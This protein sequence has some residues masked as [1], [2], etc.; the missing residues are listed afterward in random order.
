MQFD[1]MPKCTTR[2]EKYQNEPHTSAAWMCL[3]IDMTLIGSSV[4]SAFFAGHKVTTTIGKGIGG[5]L[6]A[7][8]GFLKAVAQKIKNPSNATPFGKTIKDYAIKG[9]SR[10]YLCSSAVGQAVGFV[11]SCIGSVVALPPAILI[12]PIAGYLGR[13]AA[14]EFAKGGES[15]T[16]NTFL[17]MEKLYQ[18][19]SVDG[20]LKENKEKHLA[21]L[22]S[23]NG[24]APEIPSLGQHTSKSG[25]APETVD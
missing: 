13:R 23:H 4:K 20:Y 14:L 24:V 5:I 7:G 1:N 8:A 3:A 25:S 9:V 16:F 22:N 21:K 10:G 11:S 19:H 18:K 12:T 17:R 15:A 6:G 2:V